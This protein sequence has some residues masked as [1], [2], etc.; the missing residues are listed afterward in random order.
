MRR[1]PAVG[2]F[3]KTAQQ[4]SGGITVGD[5]QCLSRQD[6]YGPFTAVSCRIGST[7]LHVPRRRLQ[8]VYRVSDSD[9]AVPAA[10]IRG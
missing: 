5:V 8:R 2:A 1:A 7:R 3:T 9:T 10:S 4:K 6:R